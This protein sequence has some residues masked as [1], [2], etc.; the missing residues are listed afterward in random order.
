M[1]FVGL[2][3]FS[4]APRTCCVRWS[5]CSYIPYNTLSSFLQ[6]LKEANN[7]TL[8]LAEREGWVPPGKLPGTPQ[9]R[10]VSYDKAGKTWIAKLQR[11]NRRKHLGHFETEEE[12]SEAYKEAVRK[13]D[14]G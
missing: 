9:R 13:L 12:A 14:S 7:I 4:S 10:G 6:F 5:A 8:P 1:G 2:S 3:S 11:G